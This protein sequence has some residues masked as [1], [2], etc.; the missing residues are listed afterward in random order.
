MESGALLLSRELR[1][2]ER[3]VEVYPKTVALGEGC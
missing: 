3:V 1:A 2:V